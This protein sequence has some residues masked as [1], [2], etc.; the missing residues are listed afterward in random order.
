MNEQAKKSKM[1][2]QTNDEKESRTPK[3]NNKNAY[4]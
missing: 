4:F 2:K 1:N 3:G